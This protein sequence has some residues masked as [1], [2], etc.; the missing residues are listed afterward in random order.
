[1]ELCENDLLQYD[2]EETAWFE[3]KKQV[4]AYNKKYS[5]RL[6]GEIAMRKK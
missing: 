4:E 2:E 5:Y 3:L 6:R 1:M